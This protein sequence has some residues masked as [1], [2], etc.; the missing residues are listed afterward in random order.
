MSYQTKEQGCF[1]LLTAFSGRV[2]AQWCSAQSDAA[3]GGGHA[4]S[5]IAF[6]RQADSRFLKS[7]GNSDVANVLEGFRCARSG[8]QLRIHEAQLRYSG[9]AK[10]YHHWSET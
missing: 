9:A 2:A 6:Q 5:S 4:T 7:H 8:D 3:S 10:G 1:F